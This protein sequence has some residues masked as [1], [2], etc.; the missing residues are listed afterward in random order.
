MYPNVAILPQ[1]IN[2]FLP[3]GLSIIFNDFSIDVS[4]QIKPNTNIPTKAA[5]HIKNS[6]SV[7]YH[8]VYK[9]TSTAHSINENI[10]SLF[11]LYKYTTSI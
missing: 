11:N 5:T 7:P 3:Y 2:A 4:I 10:V 8:M 6:V 1:T 9:I